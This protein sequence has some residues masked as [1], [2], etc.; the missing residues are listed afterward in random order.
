MTFW[1]CVN[2]GASRQSNWCRM[3]KCSIVMTST[4]AS[5]K[6]TLSRNVCPHFVSIL[7]KA[8]SVRMQIDVQTT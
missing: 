6:M 8:A 7:A 5:D 2:P 4:V 1:C 3:S